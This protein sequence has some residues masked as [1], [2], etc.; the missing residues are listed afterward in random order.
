MTAFVLKLV[1]ILAMASNHAMNAFG[2]SLAE[3]VPW[4]YVLL[5]GVGGFAFPVMAY[6]VG[7]GYD[8][9][10][11]FKNYL[12]RLV[13]FGILAQIP[14]SLAFNTATLNVMFTLALGL[15]LLWLWDN[16]PKP[17]FWVSFAAITFVSFWF[18]WGPWGPWMCFA[19]HVFRDRRWGMA[20]ALAPA[21]LDD[22][23]VAISWALAAGAYSQY[24]T[25]GYAV[26]MCATAV[27]YGLC[28]VLACVL[29]AR[30]YTGE[31]GRDARWLFYGFY[32]AHL[33]LLALVSML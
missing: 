8:H 10:R 16:L 5:S 32:P 29:I 25:A 15:I 1:A 7:E 11:S 12:L 6:L 30:V 20:A 33:F 14:Y 19:F 4:L 2:A 24:Y 13:L 9:T 17:L 18:D 22:A 23:Y 21:L 3:S 31:R 26:T 27:F 28:S